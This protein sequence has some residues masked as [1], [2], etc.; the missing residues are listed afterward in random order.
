[1]H[2]RLLDRLGAAYL[3]QAL[4]EHKDAVNERATSARPELSD[5]YEGE[6]IE[7]ICLEQPFMES[8]CAALE[9]WTSLRTKSLQQDTSGKVD[10]DHL[11]NPEETYHYLLITAEMFGL[12]KQPLKK[13]S[14]LCMAASIS[15]SVGT[16]DM[17]DNGL[18]ALSDAVHSLCDILDLSHASI[19][20]S[21]T[22]NLVDRFEPCSTSWVQFLLAKSHYLL[23]TGKYSEGEV[24]LKEAL[25]SEVFTHKS[26]KSHLLKAR[27]KSICCEYAMLPP[28]IHKFKIIVVLSLLRSSTWFTDSWNGLWM[29]FINLPKWLK[30]SLV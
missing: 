30:K 26:Y 2:S 5:S 13:A 6:E 3:W 1:M 28:T 17:L 7:D 11:I 10:L 20:L 8:L 29:Y 18:C 25:Q 4:L 24:S 12:L 23:V 21:H 27:W 22:S 9:M 14:A 15:Q 19:I 16:K